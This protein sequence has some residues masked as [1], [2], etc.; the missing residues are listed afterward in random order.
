MRLGKASCGYDPGVVERI[1]LES[2]LLEVRHCGQRHEPAGF[3]GSLSA[4]HRLGDQKR[5]R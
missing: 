3:P 5:R 2:C 1:L 4:A